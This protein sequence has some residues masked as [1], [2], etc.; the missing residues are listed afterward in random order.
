[1]HQRDDAHRFE[2]WF[3]HRFGRNSFLLFWLS[4]F[5]AWLW[6]CFHFVVAKDLPLSVDFL[7]LFFIVGF[8]VILMIAK[9]SLRSPVPP[10]A[11]R[12]QIQRRNTE[13]I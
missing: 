5:I 11:T 9:N 6:G 7:G 1:M 2:I 12:L 4:G 3:Q 8:I 13:A 10:L